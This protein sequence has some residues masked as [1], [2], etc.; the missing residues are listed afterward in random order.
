MK[1]YNFYQRYIKYK[2]KYYTLKK[3]YSKYIIDPEFPITDN[4]DSFS[5]NIYLYNHVPIN[6]LLIQ[7]QRNDDIGYLT[8]NALFYDIKFNHDSYFNFTD[9]I[10]YISQ[11]RIKILEQISKKHSEQQIIDSLTNKLDQQ[12]DQEYYNL[13]FDTASYDMLPFGNGI[14][15]F[16]TYDQKTKEMIKDIDFLVFIKNTFEQ[17]IKDF[18][19]NDS[20]LYFAK[21]N[22][23]IIIILYKCVIRLIPI[24]TFL[25]LK[26]LYEHLTKDRIHHNKIWD[27]FE[28]IFRIYISYKHSCVII[29]SEKIIPIAYQDNY[30]TLLKKQFI[31]RTDEIIC[32]I[33]KSRMYLHNIHIEHRDL[34]FDNTGYRESDDTFVIFDFDMAKS[35]SIPNIKNDLIRGYE[36]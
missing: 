12:L 36:R 33:K 3:L 25:N 27:H 29:V 22:I 7:M 32:Y 34:S 15:Y 14:H 1:Q 24:T 31:D 21:K 8:P 16:Q 4:I 13:A 2:N 10:D 9:I 26:N 30:K 6:N 35:V 19:D 23:G 20:K 5:Y 28:K 11:K 17:I 18:N